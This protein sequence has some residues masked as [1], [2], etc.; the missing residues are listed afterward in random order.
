V[1]WLIF[2]IGLCSA[3]SFEMSRRELSIDVA[4]HRSTLKN[5]EVVRILGIFKIDQRSTIPF[6]RSRRKLSIDVV[7]QVYLQN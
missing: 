5:K 3:M 4:Q 1:N 2:K 7:E 6:K